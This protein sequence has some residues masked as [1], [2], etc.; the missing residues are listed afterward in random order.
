MHSCHLFHSSETSSHLSADLYTMVSLA[1]TSHYLREHL[2]IAL[3]KLLNHSR[4]SVFSPLRRWEFQ[5]WEGL[6]GSKCVTVPN[7][8]STG[9][10]VGHFSIFKMAAAVFLNFQ[11][12]EILV[13]GTVKRIKQRHLAKFRINRSNRCWDMVIFRFFQDG[14]CLPSWICDACVWTTHEGHLVVLITVQNLVRIDAV[15]AIIC[16]F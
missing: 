11:N 6:R 13:A 15:V 16:K 4:L 8:A 2:N 3:P 9:Q 7:F 1:T 14:G 10:A 12:L 5:R